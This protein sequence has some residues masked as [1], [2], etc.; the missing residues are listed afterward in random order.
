MHLDVSVREC[1]CVSDA[2]FDEQC[3]D[4]EANG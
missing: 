4:V 3:W 1:V 2:G